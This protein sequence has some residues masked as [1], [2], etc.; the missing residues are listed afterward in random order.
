LGHPVVNLDKWDGMV[1]A[2]LDSLI[3]IVDTALT[4]YCQHND[5]V[6]IRIMYIMLN[7]IYHLSPQYAH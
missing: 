7:C 2:N 5:Y 4:Q 1:K 3:Y 6:R